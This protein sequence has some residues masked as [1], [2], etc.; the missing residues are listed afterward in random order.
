MAYRQTPAVKQRLDETRARIVSAATELIHDYGYGGCSMAA[1]ADRA[2]VATG[3]IYRFFPS[4][5]ELFAEVFRTAC[6]KEVAAASAAGQL[7][8]ESG[9]PVD[10]LIASV[11]TFARRALKAPKLAYA[12]IAEPVDPLVEAERLIYRSAYTDLFAAGIATAIHS[13]L[14]PRQNAQVTG[15]GIVGAINDVLVAP[16]GQGHADPDVIP[17]IEAFVRRALGAVSH[18]ESSHAHP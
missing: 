6:A 15:A 13:G 3:T 5:G 9:S 8:L 18:Q 16:L 12:L 11:R 10:A 4:K 17:E 2:G 14:L 7:V 1:V